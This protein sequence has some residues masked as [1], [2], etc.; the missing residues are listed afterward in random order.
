MEEA[1]GDSHVVATG[2]ESIDAAA[3]SAAFAEEDLLAS[4]IE[5]SHQSTVKRN[6]GGVENT[7]NLS[8]NH[9]VQV[10]KRYARAY[11]EKH[12]VF[13]IMEWLTAELCK[14]QPVKPLR[15]IYSLLK[16]R[17][18][19]AQ[20]KCDS[21]HRPQV[22]FVTGGPC[23]GKSTL[24]QRLA[25]DY[26]WAHLR[27]ESRTMIVDAESGEFLDEQRLE[28]IARAVCTRIHREFSRGKTV[29]LI[30]GFP[31]S[32]D[33]FKVWMRMDLDETLTVRRVL[34][35]NV[36]AAIL[37]ERMR[38]D[39]PDQDKIDLI[40]RAK[41][42]EIDAAKMMYWIDTVNKDGVHKIDGSMDI[43]SVYESVGEIIDEFNAESLRLLDITSA[44]DSSLM[45]NKIL[46]TRCS[47]IF[48]F[49]P[50]YVDAAS[51]VC[52]RLEEDQPLLQQLGQDPSS[53]NIANYPRDTFRNF[54]HLSTSELLH[55]ELD[56][57]TNS[58][59]AMLIRQC[60]KRGDAVP[61]D[62][63][64]QVLL[65]TMRTYSAQTCFLI[66]GFPRSI[67][68]AEAWNR[69]INELVPGAKSTLA[70]AAMLYFEFDENLIESIAIHS[71]AGLEDHD[72]A[73]FK[74]KVAGRL[75]V[76]NQV[77]RPT[78]E[79]FQEKGGLVS[80]F[81]AEQPLD[82]VYSQVVD[83]LSSL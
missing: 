79:H 56:L 12:D 39:R 60:L 40:R 69:A 70:T 47:V 24:C 64:T 52:Q 22:I 14:R 67:A 27:V 62:I 3:L 63:V 78:I 7:S 80:V 57:N 34:H 44:I 18:I 73:R 54:V 51:V 53:K 72:L 10:L 83:L 81:N 25:S 33:M 20:Q 2:E 65:S 74:A 68:N 59:R 6:V 43:D 55:R 37:A 66:E 1:P 32:Q 15:Y 45:D 49:S 41:N 42:Y 31:D 46:A 48:I 77:T 9:H 36:S 23:S 11:L 29:I 5:S 8:L 58:A 13:E 30:D 38:L 61:D 19:A 17:L 82:E 16:R 28:T 75:E 76:F 71:N 50:P 35:L 21:F 4:V 26:G